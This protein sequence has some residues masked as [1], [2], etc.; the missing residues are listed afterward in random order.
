MKA[1][2]QHCQLI[3]SVCYGIDF[4]YSYY[5]LMKNGQVS[6]NYIC[7]L[8]TLHQ[9]FSQIPAEKY[10]YVGGSDDWFECNMVID[11]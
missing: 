7:W 5:T 2:N 3:A 11:W 4:I 1:E 8:K 10:M 6:Q 9:D